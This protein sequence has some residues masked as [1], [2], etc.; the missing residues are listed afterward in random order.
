MQNDHLLV[1]TA[2]PLVLFEYVTKHNNLNTIFKQVETVL[3]DL[4]ANEYELSNFLAN[5]NVA[6]Q[7]RKEVLDEIYLN[8]IDQYLLNFLKTTIDFNR[9]RNL[10]KIL[11]SFLGMCNDYLGITVLKIHSPFAL[12]KQQMDQLFNALSKKYGK[13]IQLI[14]VINPSLIGG[15]KLTSDSVSIDRSYTSQLQS[16]KNASLMAINQ[17]VDKEQENE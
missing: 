6:K 15:I 10:I 1:N 14:N 3:K 17:F 8:Q 13:Q 12:N 4:K 9:A 7:E 5:V 16:I 11:K 2:Y